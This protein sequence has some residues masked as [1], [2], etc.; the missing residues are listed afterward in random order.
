MNPSALNLRGRMAY[1]LDCLLVFLAQ[2]QRDLQFYKEEIEVLSQY[3]SATNLGD[4]DSRANK[5]I[6][7][8]YPEEEY[9]DVLPGIIEDLYWIGAGELY[10]QP[11][12]C[13]ESEELLN[14]ILEIL[15]NNGIAPPD[16]MA[17]ASHQLKAP[18]STADYFGVPFLY[19]AFQRNLSVQDRSEKTKG[20]RKDV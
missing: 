13:R 20:E 1:G 19:D 6:F 10:G 9:E 16:L 5:L 12:T 4:W 15:Q 2:N 14:H 7:T 3:T 8:K 18:V 11:S 17:Y